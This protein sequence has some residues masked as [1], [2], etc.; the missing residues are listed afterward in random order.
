MNE[1]EPLTAEELRE[2]QANSNPDDSVDIPQ[3]EGT[4]PAEAAKITEILNKK[5]GQMDEAEV[6]EY[7][8]MQDT[9]DRGGIIADDVKAGNGPFKN[10]DDMLKGDS[11]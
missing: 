7:Q 3:Y 6:H 1:Q 9:A 11:K 5:I 10:D 8:V 4:S 2:M